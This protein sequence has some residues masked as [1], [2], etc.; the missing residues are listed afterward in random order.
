MTPYISIDMFKNHRRRGVQVDNL[1]PRGTPAEQDAALQEVI[2]SASAE[3]DN[4][5]LGILAATSDTELRRV[6]VDRHGYAAVHPRFRPIIALTAF[7]I[8][9]TPNTMQALTDFTGTGL[10]LNRFTV[11]TQPLALTSSQGPLQFGSNL[12][13][14]ADQA[15]CQ[16]TYQN[17]YPVTTLTANAAQGATSIAVA[18]TT[19]IVQG[20]TWLTIYALQNRIRFQAGAVST[21]PTAGQV[22]TGPGTVGCPALPQ[23][24]PNSPTY[25]TMV[26]A[27]PPDVIEAVVLITRAIIK[28][29][30][31]GSVVASGNRNTSSSDKDPF[32][33]GDDM[34]EAETK[35]HPYLVPWE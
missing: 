25:P 21:A 16:Y 1:V 18:D 13:T 8:G 5:V 33:S 27:L 24:I 29:T 20:Q 9:A 23:A 3:V 4:I 6:N 15:W 7:Q 30:G 19:G 10:E 17:G 34:V 2:E 35:L 14:P 11:P 22:G 31:G 32:G 12:T 26:S 28:E